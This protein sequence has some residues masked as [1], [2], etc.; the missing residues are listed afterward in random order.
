MELCTFCGIERE[1]VVYG[2]GVCICELCVAEVS[3]AVEH[4]VQGGGICSFCLEPERDSRFAFRRRKIVA[5]SAAGDV[6]ICSSCLPIIQDV[7][8]RNRKAA[9]QS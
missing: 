9:S 1:H 8:H 4:P 6:R 2:P 7:D 5:A 3:S